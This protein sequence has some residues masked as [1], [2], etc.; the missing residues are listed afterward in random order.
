MRLYVTYAV[1]TYIWIFDQDTCCCSEEF[2]LIDF[3]LSI[4]KRASFET[5]SL[6]VFFSVFLT[7][8][9]FVK[10]LIWMLVKKK[11][12]SFIS[13]TLIFVINKF[14]LYNQTYSK[15]KYYLILWDILFVYTVSFIAKGR[16]NA[17]IIKLNNIKK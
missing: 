5:Y 10:N 7:N 14:Y 15:K 1:I 3:T 9:Q 4:I 6:T 2:L 8:A 11:W 17:R 12:E 16:S 13:F